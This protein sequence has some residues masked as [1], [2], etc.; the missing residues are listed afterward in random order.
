MSE[1]ESLGEALPKECARVRELQGLYKVIG[2]SGA[3]AHEMMERALRRADKAMIEN[4]IVAML[5]VYKELKEFT[6]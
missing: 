4:D 1:P 6:A 2:K 3:F 5:Q